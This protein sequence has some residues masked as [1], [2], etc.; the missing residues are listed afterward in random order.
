[1]KAILVAL[2]SARGSLDEWGAYG[3][4]ASASIY[5]PTVKQLS[6]KDKHGNTLPYV[7]VQ[8]RDDLSASCDN[9]KVYDIVTQSMQFVSQRQQ[10]EPT[11]FAANKDN[12]L[13]VE[14]QPSIHPTKLRLK[15]GNAGY[16]M[17]DGVN[18]PVFV[19]YPFSMG[20]VEDAAR[21][22]Y[23]KWVDDYRGVRYRSD[24]VLT[25]K[26]MAAIPCI[27]EP[28]HHI[29]IITKILSFIKTIPVPS[30]VH[31]LDKFID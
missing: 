21:L 26:N 12:D 9:Y 11:R 20:D 25:T 6:N 15:S 4:N 14:Y 22:E 31:T 13:M 17:I 10:I 5:Q 27:D 19:I 29:D 23:V 30:E 24:G 16:V 8:V 1:M 7:V 2:G 18:T 28:A 3:F